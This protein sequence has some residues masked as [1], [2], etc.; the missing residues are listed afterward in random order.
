MTRQQYGKYLEDEREK[1]KTDQ[2]QRRRKQEDVTSCPAQICLSDIRLPL[3]WKDSDHF[4]NKGDHR[5]YAVFCL[6]RIGTNI[7]DTALLKDVDRSMTD[8]TFDDI[9][10][11]D[12]V[13][14]DFE[15]HLEVY[16]HKLCTDLS[17]ASTPQK[18]RKHFNVFSNTVG[19]SVGKR[20]SGLKQDTDIM[21]NMLVG[22]KFQ[23]IAKATLRLDEVKAAVST[24][25]L[26][27]NSASDTDDTSDGGSHTELPLFGHF[28]CRLAAQPQ[29]LLNDLAL[30]YL[31]VKPNLDVE[32]QRL[33]CQ[34]SGKELSC[35]PQQPTSPS[36][37]PTL[38]IPITKDTTV[39]TGDNDTSLVT[40]LHGTSPVTLASC[41]GQNKGKWLK[42]FQQHIHD[43]VVWKQAG[44]QLMTFPPST[45]QAPRGR[46]WQYY[47]KVYERDPQCLLG[48]VS[49]VPGG[50]ATTRWQHYYKVYE[51]DPQC[52]LGPVSL[53]PGGSTNYKVYERDT[54]SPVGTRVFGSRWQHYY[55]V[56]ERDPQCLL[57]P[58]SLVPGGSTTKA[59]C[60]TARPTVPVGTRVFGSRWQHYYKV[61]ERDPQCL[62]G[63]VS[64]VP[65]GSTTTRWQH[66]YKVYERDPQCLLGPV[67]L[68]PGIK[69]GE[70][71]GGFGGW[72]GCGG[73]T[74]TRC[75]SETHSACWDPCL[76]FQ[77]AALL[78]G[79]RW[80]H[81]YKV[82]GGS[83]T[84]RFQVAAL[85]QDCDSPMTRI[86]NRLNVNDKTRE[87]TSHQSS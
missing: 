10:I 66:Y 26:L 73:S 38:S 76:W 45:P 67:S 65:A 20:L 80:Q 70:R 16:G 14:A 24:Y 36:M 42:V 39:T 50:S 58:V 31:Q 62:L 44:D 69:G 5:R 41:D 22:P 57:G 87:N 83:T 2:K 33:W 81:Y 79:S 8:L 77:V 72:G 40:Q 47:Y 28:C 30:G 4:K 56:Y 6:V 37:P 46:R 84:T 85:L 74:T 15:C 12:S 61:Y 71:G 19:R 29:C 27:I 7:Q 18:I 25:D 86:L 3:M 23:I 53:V 68:V 52:L 17:I 49:L 32:S 55:K 13:K 63:P 82:P 43:Q 34:L 1:K 35:W 54:K 78:Q 75:M 60:M 48:P 9:L 64:L 51:R 59:R 21:A 11:F